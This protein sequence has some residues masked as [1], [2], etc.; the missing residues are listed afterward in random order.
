MWKRPL[1]ENVITTNK[2]WYI[3]YIQ[4]EFVRQEITKA[5]FISTAFHFLNLQNSLSKVSFVP[6]LG[7]IF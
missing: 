7:F 2:T 5:F 4:L 3:N 6:E 1:R